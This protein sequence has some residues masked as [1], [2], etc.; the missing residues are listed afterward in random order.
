[1]SRENVLAA[2]RR[3]A[4]AGMVDTCTIRRISGE[5][6]D[7]DTGQVTATHEMLYT[8]P[9]RV[10]QQGQQSRPEQPGEAY[11]LMLR[12]ELQLPMSVTGLAV[13]DQVTIDAS[14]HDADLVGRVFRVRD[15]AH[16]SHATARRMGCEEVTS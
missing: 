1:M 10:Q 8:G 4:E 9:C 16:K 12:L 2:G 3:A 6:T 14:A 7:E 11:V 5:T 15:L 13:D